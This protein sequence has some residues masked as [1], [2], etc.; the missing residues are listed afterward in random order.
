MTEKGK[1][2]SLNVLSSVIIFSDMS[3]IHT[4]AQHPPPY[5]FSCILVLYGL[6]CTSQPLN[7]P[8]VFNKLQDSKYAHFVSVSFGVW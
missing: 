2:E 5:K 6:S 1:N 4:F 7:P 8:D 3:L